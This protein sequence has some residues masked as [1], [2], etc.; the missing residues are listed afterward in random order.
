[1]SQD[2]RP[3]TYHRARIASAVQRGDT[4]EAEAARRDMK[5]ARL[6]DHIRSVVGSTPAPSVE[7]RARLAALLVPAS[8]EASAA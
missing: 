5:T 6:A 7:Q 2:D 3:W 4:A 8:G 1:M